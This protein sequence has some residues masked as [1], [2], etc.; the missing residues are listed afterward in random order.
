MLEG[1]F[2]IVLCGVLIP[3]TRD[4]LASGLWWTPVGGGGRREGLSWVDRRTGTATW[5]HSIAGRGGKGGDLVDLDLCQA[6]KC[7]QGTE[8]VKIENQNQNGILRVCF[9]SASLSSLFLAT[10]RVRTSI[11]HGDAFPFFSSFRR[12][13]CVKHLWFTRSLARRLAP[14]CGHE[15]GR[16]ALQDVST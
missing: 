2:S 1:C 9:R 14:S 10:K 8:E 12:P 6:R 13:S 3:S 16:A 11:L 7:E 4:K 15:R 5:T